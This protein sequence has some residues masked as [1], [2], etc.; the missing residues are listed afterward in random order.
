MMVA[1]RPSCGTD[2]SSILAWIADVPK[3]RVSSFS[4]FLICTAQQAYG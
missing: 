4:S 2:R 1:V 3:A